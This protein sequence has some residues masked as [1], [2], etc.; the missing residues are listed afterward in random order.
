MADREPL[1]PDSPS[2]NGD[3]RRNQERP[4]VRWLQRFNVRYQ[5]RL[6]TVAIAGIVYSAAIKNVGLLAAFVGL[7]LAPFVVGKPGE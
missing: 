2:T 4:A 1:R 7:A 5:T 3:G 6:Q